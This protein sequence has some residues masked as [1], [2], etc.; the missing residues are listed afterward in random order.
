M[1]QFRGEQGQCIL[2]GADG[3]DLQGTI[4][5]QSKIEGLNPKVPK[6]LHYGMPINVKTTR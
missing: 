6:S 5:K 4:E 3:I 2:E 1:V